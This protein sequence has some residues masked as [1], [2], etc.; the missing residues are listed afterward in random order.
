MKQG[1]IHLIGLDL[2]TSAIKGILIDEQ[3]RTVAQA[4]RTTDLLR[5]RDGWV[6]VDPENHYRRVCEVLRELS[7]AA[8]G[9][10]CAFSMAAASGN[11]LLTDES[12]EPLT[13]IINWMDRRAELEP[14][15]ALEEFDQADVIRVTGWPCV[16][17]FPLAHL[18]WLRA[19]RPEIYARAGHIGMDTDWLTYRLTGQWVMDRSTAATFHLQEQ[20]AG[21]Y[22]LPFLNR[23]GVPTEKLSTLV[24]SGAAVGSLTGRAAADTGL[25]ASTVLVA[26]CFDHPAAARAVG[27]LA[28]GQMILS[29]GTSWVGFTPCADRDRILD[30]GMLCDP[31]LSANG[32]AWGGIFSVPYIGQNIDWYIRNVIAPGE[33]HPMQVFDDSAAESEPGAGGLVI[34]L[35]R[36]PMRVEADRKHVSRA[37]MEGA[38][39]LLN[40]KIVGMRD[41][42]FRCESAVMV[43][44]PADSR[45]WPRIVEQITGMTVTAQGRSAGAKGAAM[46]AGIGVGIYADEHHALAAW[47]DA[48]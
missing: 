46:L 45:V 34:D 11:T 21:T 32:G 39:R 12:G 4:H 30:A 33:P 44:G 22:H 5:P 41:W 17:T 16:T 9:E 24:D 25:S 13:N 38:V 37:V 35:T 3:G 20:T 23:L 18:A 19:N 42:G 2:G 14:L 27:V 48:P 43:G 8:P 40:E 1:K 15:P 10:V 47:N 6:E 7:N 36:P 26:G 31:F 29:C 28:P